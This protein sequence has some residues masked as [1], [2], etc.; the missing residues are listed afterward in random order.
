M[1]YSS[2][3]A[4]TFLSQC[5][6]QKQND[7]NSF[8]PTVLP[9]TLKNMAER[10]YMKTVSRLDFAEHLNKH[11]VFWVHRVLG[12]F[13]VLPLENININVHDSVNLGV[14]EK[15][16][17]WNHLA[18]INLDLDENIGTKI[19]FNYSEIIIDVPEDYKVVTDIPDVC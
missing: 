12:G 17:V 8:I 14:K 15:V 7:N 19:V 9:A 13:L 16:K 10:I 2:G 4:H 6:K 3:G 5:V 11:I 1:L 18:F